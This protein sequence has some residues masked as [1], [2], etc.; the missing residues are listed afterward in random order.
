MP[1]WL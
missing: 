1:A